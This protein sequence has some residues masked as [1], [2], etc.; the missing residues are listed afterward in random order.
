M[1]PVIQAVHSLPTL[2][3]HYRQFYCKFP[4][5]MQKSNLAAIL[6]NMIVI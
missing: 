4:I 1:Q 6:I 5:Y 3:Q 2:L